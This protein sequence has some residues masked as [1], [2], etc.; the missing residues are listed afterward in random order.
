MGNSTPASD[1]V[2]TAI[3][4]QYAPT[5]PSTTAARGSYELLR[6]LSTNCEL[7]PVD[8]RI[9]KTYFKH[10]QTFKN[11]TFNEATLQDIKY[12]VTRFPE[13][14]HTELGFI[15]MRYAMTPLHIAILNEQVPIELIG[16]L[17]DNGAHPNLFYNTNDNKRIHL[18]DDPHHVVSVH[19][20]KLIEDILLK[21]PEYIKPK[22]VL[23]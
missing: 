7:F 9:N 11:K 2:T 15:R 14:L 5:T 22:S 4:A 19:R 20:R 16:W 1:M 17:L 10:N 21:H 13:A 3:L 12:I 23:D 18:F 6:V 8:C